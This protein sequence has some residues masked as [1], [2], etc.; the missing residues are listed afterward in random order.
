ME[1]GQQFFFGLIISFI[2]KRK[3]K[4]RSGSRR[5]ITRMLDINTDNEYENQRKLNI[6]F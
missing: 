6:L 3:E 5:R 1:K 2:Q 4:K